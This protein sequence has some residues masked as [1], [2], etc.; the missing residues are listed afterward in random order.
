MTVVLV[1][2]V[3]DTPFMWTP[4]V[5]ALGLSDGEYRTPSLPG[6][7]HPA[8]QGFSATKEAYASW[9]VGEIQEAV[10]KTGSP[11]DIVGHD[12]GSL[13]VTRAV[14]MRPDLVRTWTASN[15][16][17]DP[18]YRGHRMAR[19]W[20]TP[21]IGELVMWASQS[22]DFT[23]ALEA[24]GL[25]KEIAQ[26]EARHWTKDM[27]SNILRLYRSARG[28]RFGGPW[29]DELEKLPERGLIIWGENDPYVDL[30]VAERFSNRWNTPLK[31]IHGTGH[32]GLIERPEEAAG[33]L[34]A[35]WKHGAD[36]S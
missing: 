34:K 12:W 35:H 18:D 20:A 21:L 14:C 30:S 23:E 9:L 26:H 33:Y 15:A 31:V 29:V 7:E 28:L 10:A 17:I 5:E 32:W 6:F 19:L 1:H 8:P 36:D 2:G 13:L 24:A 25:P 11:V 4:L 27:R 16:L 22:R 3:P